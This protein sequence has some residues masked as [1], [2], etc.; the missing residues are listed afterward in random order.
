MINIRLKTIAK[1]AAID[2][3]SSGGVTGAE[4][5]EIKLMFG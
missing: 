5:R 3:G 2:N 4:S 1:I